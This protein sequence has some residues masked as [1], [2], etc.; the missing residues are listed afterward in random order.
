MPGPARQDTRQGED[1]N[2]QASDHRDPKDREERAIGPEHTNCRQ[3]SR[4]SDDDK[5]NKHACPQ[6]QG[7]FCNAT[8]DEPGGCGLKLTV[9]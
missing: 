2:D 8:H 6:S 4:S 7:H 1:G 3:A 9:R 5:S